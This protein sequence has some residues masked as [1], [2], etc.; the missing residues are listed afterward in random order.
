MAHV[1]CLRTVG[2]VLLMMGACLAG[3]GKTEPPEAGTAPPP[4]ATTGDIDRLRSLPYVDSMAARG[5]EPE[6]VVFCDAERVCPGYNLYE[7]QM[8]SRA[9][10]IDAQG[11]VLRSW[12]HAPSDRWERAELLPNGDLVAVGAAPYVWKDG[13]PP[14][15]IADE[16]RYVLRL[17]WHG[18]VLWKKQLR[19][20]HDI[21]PVPDGK[22]LVLTFERRMEPEINAQVPT[23]DD[24][25]TLLNADG[26]VSAAHSML[27]A[28]RRS[29]KVFRLK[30][31]GPSVLGGP[32]WV[33]VFHSNSVE[34]LHR[35]HLVGRHPLYDLG[36][37]L[38]CFRHQD[39][40]AVFNWERNEVV[41]AWGEEELSG[42]HDAQVLENGHIL[43]FDNG[44]GRGASRVLEIDPLAGQIVWRY[45]AQ[46]ATSFYTASKGSAQ[47][48][49]NGNTL[50]A[51]SDKGRA[52]EV[53][54][55]GE[56]VWEFVSPHRVK[57][58]ERAAIVRMRRVPT[59]L[60]DALN[61]QSGR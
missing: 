55:A 11:R 33:D 23:R 26:T 61:A 1:V 25:L 2:V 39:R 3:C 58:S 29:A 44:L 59:V 41:W 8:L 14:E 30:R 49:P 12:N 18:Q 48:L 36:N 46:P 50:I 24:Y 19:A 32:P 22:L 31:V 7:V 28:V 38:V 20:H 15:R 34:W 56:V 13:G 40:I 52:F 47:R 51:E 60:V 21:T 43:V 5:D 27:A 10:L 16:S 45:Q 9:E 57:G 42:P 4:A 17:D 54:P 35:E 53:T 37:I 6:G